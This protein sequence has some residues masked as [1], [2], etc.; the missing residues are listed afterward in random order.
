VQGNLRA[1][2]AEPWVHLHASLTE[3]TRA[4]GT[5]ANTFHLNPD[6][7]DQMRRALLPIPDVKSARARAE[8]RVTPDNG[9]ALTLRQ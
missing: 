3:I 6:E 4:L 7:K 1:W 9:S 5:I 8:G 2:G